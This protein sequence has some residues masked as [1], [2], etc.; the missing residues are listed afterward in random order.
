MTGHHPPELASMITGMS[1]GETGLIVSGLVDSILHPKA[2]P[3]QTSVEY[4]CQIEDRPH[5]DQ[6]QPQRGKE[7]QPSHRQ[8]GGGFLAEQNCH[9]FITYSPKSTEG[10][11]Q[12][13]PAT[14]RASNAK[15][16][17]LILSRKGRNT[18]A[19]FSCSMSVTSRLS[20]RT[21]VLIACGTGGLPGGNW[22]KPG[23]VESKGEIK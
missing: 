23:R 3:N 9:A 6:I 11:N 16:K 15:K 4:C 1:I 17:H 2:H 10:A 20:L 14:A 19:C 18:S 21:P 13:L 22:N 12:V 5:R 8:G 7:P